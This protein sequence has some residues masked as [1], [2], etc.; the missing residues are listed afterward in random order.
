MSEHARGGCATSQVFTGGRRLSC[1][2]VNVRVRA[3]AVTQRQR[4]LARRPSTS[5]GMT[6]ANAGIQATSR[7]AWDNTRGQLVDVLRVR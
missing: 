7:S 1:S 4:R 2:S 6:R 3:H 5:Q